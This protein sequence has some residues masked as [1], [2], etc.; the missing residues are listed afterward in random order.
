MKKDLT[1]LKS[2]L[3]VFSFFVLMRM[4]FCRATDC[5]D[6]EYS[7]GEILLKLKAGYALQSAAAF[8][9]L[10][11]KYGV[12][13]SKQLFKNFDPSRIKQKSVPG[14]LEA[15]DLS[16]IFKLKLSETADIIKAVEEYNQADGVE[17][18]EPNYIARVMG[19]PDD[20]YF[21]QQWGLD[22]IDAPEA[23]DITT[24]SPD[25]II[26]IIDTGIDRDHPDLD[27]K[28]WTNAGEIPGNDVDD[29][30][31]GYVDDV[32]GWNW[33]SVEQD[34]DD[35]D[36][37]NPRD[38]NGHGTHVAG[39]A[40]AETNNAQGVAGVCPDCGIMSLKAF[41]SDGTGNYSDIA[42]AIYYASDIGAKVINMSFAGESHSATMENALAVAYSSS[43]LVAA[44]GN[45]ACRIGV[46]GCYCCGLF[47]CGN[48]FFPAAYNFV[49]GIGAVKSN[50]E[51][52]LFSNYDQDGS[53]FSAFDQEYNYD[54]DAPGSNIYSSM[55]G[56]AYGSMTG[57]SM[58]APF[59]SGTIGLLIDYHPDW[60][61]ELIRGQ[62][63][64]ASDNLNAYS[65][66]TV[67]PEP[68]L[69][70]QDGN[71]TYDDSAGDNDGRVDSG[72][73]VGLI[74]P[75]KNYW[76]QA[77]GVTA[78]LTSSDPW[79]TIVNN[80]SVY[81][82]ISPYASMDNTGDM[83]IFFLS[84][85]CPNNHTVSLDISITANEGDYSSQISVSFDAERGMELYG[86]ISIDT[87]LHSD[88]LYIVTGNLYVE[89][90]VTL[91]LEK[92][93]RLQFFPTLYMRVDGT[94][95]AVGTE[96]EPIVFT[97]N[98]TSPTSGDWGYIH[99]Y[100][101]SNDAVYDA[102]NNYIS[103]ATIQY[104]N[105]EYASTG[106]ILTSCE[107][108][109][110]HNYIA[111]NN[112][113]GTVKAGGIFSTGID[114]SPLICHNVISHN[115]SQTHQAAAG[116]H[117]D[118][119]GILQNNTIIENSSARTTA[120]VYATNAIIE[121]NLILHN[122]S[123]GY[124]GGAIKIV[125]SFLNKNLIA[126]NELKAGSHFAGGGGLCSEGDAS[127]ITNNTIIGNIVDG[128]G[129][130]RVFGSGVLLLFN[131]S[132]EFNSNNIY[133]NTCLNN[134][135]VDSEFSIRYMN[136]IN[137]PNNWWGTTDTDIIDDMIW[138][139]YDDPDNF[140]G[141][142][143]YE[144]IATEPISTA[145]PVL[146]DVTLDPLSPV[147]AETVTFTLTFSKPMDTSVDPFITFGV[148]DPFTQHQI[149]GSWDV[150]E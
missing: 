90:G 86:S 25:I 109:I 143:I 110:A 129:I 115:I 135:N 58:A 120:G 66:L 113:T 84:E 145:P 43:L 6:P 7:P 127:A 144:P 52:P 97:S 63:N 30:G 16:N 107:P 26:A 95:M 68:H 45:N 47:C 2:F 149:T 138:D 100:G 1:G 60:S 124:E 83:F 53:C 87:T 54:F 140:P 78:T 13:E 122:K 28:I 125:D 79:V 67:V 91:T 102:Y 94:I 72:E 40:A 73:T 114:V 10:N 131:N 65:E 77:E 3:I 69:V 23:W 103:G 85:D 44:T 22:D 75:L 76:G 31:N 70:F 42:E 89:P 35:Y 82:T 111:F 119:G 61:H 80:T 18:A 148:D 8:Q 50:G 128:D 56:S 88:Y 11:Q 130:Y 123:E 19:I 32:W 38:D 27:D 14:L 57:T 74:I 20:T 147:G 93:L 99:L 133:G 141:K 29:D 117:L 39:I 142:V 112:S 59:A 98:S 36:F 33:A 101:S 96:E 104:A 37:D 62:L 41:R 132:I 4:P 17:Y 137:I 139:F 136:D 150:V 21:D 48:R 71:E 55:F 15:P 5:G 116:V 118:G 9:A 49:L 126:Y 108:Y 24:G 146:V 12:T 134:P 105:I 64:H 106:L 81:G 34:P 51:R 92:G 121:E 46:P